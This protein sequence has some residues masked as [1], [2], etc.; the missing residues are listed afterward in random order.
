MTRKFTGSGAWPTPPGRGMTAQEIREL[1]DAAPTAFRATMEAASMFQ[2]IGEG[3]D[4]MADECDHPELARLYRAEADATRRGDQIE[5]FRIW[6]AIER[7]FFG[8]PNE[9]PAPE[10]TD[11]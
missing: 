10:V 7:H 6:G 4:R 1:R 5:S 9:V 8:D 3:M 2:I 11:E